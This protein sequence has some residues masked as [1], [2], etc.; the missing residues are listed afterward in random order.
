MKKSNKQMKQKNPSFIL[1][2]PLITT[3]SDTRILNI[4]LESARQ[5]YSAVLGESLKRLSL[6]KESMQWQ[7]A[8]S[9]AK[10]NPDKPKIFKTCIA[11][12]KFTDYDLQS[13]G[14][15]CK[16]SCFIGYHLD[17]HTAQK[18]STR[19]FKSA[20]R[21]QFRQSGKPRFK[22]KWKSLTSV[23]SKTNNAG[24]RWRDDHIE[25]SGLN[26]KAI[27]DKKDKHGVQ[28]YA[29]QSNVKY[30]RIVSKFIKG[31]QRFY[32]QLILSGFP[33]IK[34][35]NIVTANKAC[36]DI[37]PS[38]IALV[39]D[40][41]AFLKEFCPNAKQLKKH[42]RRIQRA[43]DISKR[44]S[45][46]D[47]F[48]INGTVKKGRLK[49]VFTNGYIR[50]KA[51][52]SELHRVLAAYRKTEH[53]RLANIVLSKANIIKAE[54]LSYKSFQKNYSKSVR[55]K[56]PGMFMSILRRKAENA[57]GEV[58][59][60]P[61]NTTKLSQTCQCG[62]IVKKPLSQRWHVCPVCG[63]KAQRDLYSAYLGL[64]VYQDND[65]WN[66]DIDSACKS[67]N[68]AEPLLEKAM[69]NVIQIA[70]GGFIPAS[71]GIK[72]GDGA[73]PSRSP[74]VTQRDLGC[75]NNGGYSNARA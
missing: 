74:V 44:L 9:L 25:W 55:D 57:G 20:Q 54:K 3:N 36:I 11:Q 65:V 47:N 53:G 70:N 43:M 60:F 62:I 63:V 68:T 69:S 7:Y 13:Y 38:T 40:K 41:D 61:T 64:F 58:I 46:P 16:N 32:V 73:I 24:I 51:K 45:N 22:S 33:K 28:A 75:C 56:A 34:S 1:E 59:E 14:T 72:S 66:L 5:L 18:I 29:L 30:C 23:E 37:G 48:N 2:L 4:R 6:M 10:D 8:R 49:W 21:Y 12:Y 15:E 71:F 42:I 67:W 17:A 26:L 19:A 39:S 27:F 50:L 31:K 52:L 35:K